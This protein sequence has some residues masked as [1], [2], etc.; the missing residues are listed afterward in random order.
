MND[1]SRGA[2]QVEDKDVEM[3]GVCGRWRDVE[4]WE[5]AAS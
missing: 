2:R 4:V 3:M 5:E 1:V